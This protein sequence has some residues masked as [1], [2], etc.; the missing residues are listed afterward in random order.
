MLEDLTLLSCSYNTPLHLLTML[1]SFVKVHGDGPWNCLIMENSTNDDTVK[2]LEKNKV[3]YIRN[4]GGTHSKSIDLLFKECKTKYAILVDSDIIFIE[5]VHP[6]LSVMKNNDGALMG[7]VCGDRGGYRLHPRVHPWF[8]VVDTEKIKQHSIV[9]H[10]QKRIDE[11]N[12]QYFYSSVPINPFKNNAIPKYDVGATFYEDI[13]KAKLNILEA[14]GITKYFIHFEGSSW[15]T[16]SGHPGFI[17][18]GNTIY[19]KFKEVASNY[20]NSIDQKFI[21][22]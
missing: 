10:D 22:K 12:S 2:I 16:K 14:K 13:C 4:A 1:R 21:R 19:N 5:K 18:L 8:C 20:Q 3:P 6:L 7:E 17:Q 11:T 9:F 15:H